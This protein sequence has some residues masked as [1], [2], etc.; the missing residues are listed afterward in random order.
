MAKVDFAI[1]G[2]PKSATTLVQRVLRSHGHIF[3][4]EG[5]NPLFNSAQWDARI[6]ALLQQAEASGRKLCGIKRP[7][8]LFNI[9]SARRLKSHNA[10]VKAV[11]VLRHPVERAVAHYFHNVRYG[12]LPFLDIGAGVR[13]LLSGEIQ[14]DWPRGHEV[15]GFS[16][17]GDAMTGYLDTLGQDQVRYFT[18]DEVKADA[19]GVIRRVCD[20]LGVSS[21]GDIVLPKDRPQKV[22][23]AMERLRFLRHANEAT[24]EMDAAGRAV[25]FKPLPL[26]EHDEAWDYMVAQFDQKVM[27]DKYPNVPPRLDPATWDMLYAYFRDD[28]A[29]TEALLGRAL[30][31]WHLNPLA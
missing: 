17:Y 5:E 28:I 25:R 3:L 26:S 16:R 14:R 4:E 8:M 20:F 24:M 30:P 2:V 27:A 9:E 31:S 21:A 7:D 1:V 12:F 15:L 18:H 29:R 10:D 13:G 22:M 19:V 6:G 23:Y 11:A